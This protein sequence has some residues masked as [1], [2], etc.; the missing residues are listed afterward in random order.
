MRFATSMIYWIPLFFGLLFVTWA[1]SVLTGGTMP[2][3]V[4]SV[5]ATGLLLSFVITRI[6][7]K[8]GEPRVAQ[9]MLRVAMVAADADHGAI[10]KPSMSRIILA[11]KLLEETASSP[12]QIRKAIDAS[13]LASA[14]LVAVRGGR[15]LELRTGRH[16]EHVILTV[17]EGRFRIAPPPGIGR[18]QILDTE[19]GL[20]SEFPVMRVRNRL[21]KPATIAEATEDLALHEKVIG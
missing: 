19:G 9:R 12:E 2:G 7:Y 8:Y 6:A 20:V 21:L 17:P 15:G 11:S 18:V 16:S 10:L 4:N 3:V 14:R 1:V 5:F 13:S